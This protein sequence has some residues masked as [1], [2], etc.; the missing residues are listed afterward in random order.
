[1]GKDPTTGMELMIAGRREYHSVEGIG[2]LFHEAWMAEV[3]ALANKPK[4]AVELCQKIRELKTESG[5]GSGD[6][7]VHRALAITAAQKSRPAWD[8]VDRH[9]QTA[10]QVAIDCG[11]RPD[12]A[13]THYR[14]AELLSKKGA[15][16]QAQ[17]QLTEA[18]L[19]FRDMEMTWWLEQAEAL[20]KSL[21]AN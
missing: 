15:H 3:F 16:M 13:I 21:G 5:Q 4:E 2:F 20:G 6:I 18:V 7:H 9:M 10:I 19:Q 12:R 14:Y 8:K 1:M 11:A 17:E